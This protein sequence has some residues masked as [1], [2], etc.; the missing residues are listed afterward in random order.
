MT[1]PESKTE[2]EVDEAG[3]FPEVEDHVEP[4]E[5]EEDEEDNGV[6]GL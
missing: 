1:L 2:K 4:V 5:D 6:F 3:V